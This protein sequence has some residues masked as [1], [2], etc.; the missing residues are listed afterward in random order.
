[1]SRFKIGDRA[2]NGICGDCA[3]EVIIISDE[4]KSESGDLYYAI[5]DVEDVDSEFPSF[6]FA[7][8]LFRT[9][10]EAIVENKRRKKEALEKACDSIHDVSDLVKMMYIG[11]YS[12]KNANQGRI[13]IAKRKAKELLD[14]EL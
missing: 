13:E 4:L 10:E 1:M 14:I 7:S 5:R 9:E 2:W 12:N 6:V 3:E 8:R 11:L